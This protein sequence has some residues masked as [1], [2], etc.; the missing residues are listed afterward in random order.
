MVA[1]AYG[2]AVLFAGL[3]GLVATLEIPGDQ[4]YLRGLSSFLIGHGLGMVVVG[5]IISKLNR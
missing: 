3:V 1:A 4:G 2:F 5:C